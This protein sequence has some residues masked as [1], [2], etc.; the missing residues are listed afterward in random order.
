MAT[1]KKQLRD[2]DGNTI[3]PDVG[4]DLDS[5]VFSDDPTEPV[6]SLEPWIETEDITDGAIT[7]DKID[8]S[9]FPHII[10]C[11]TKNYSALNS[12]GYTSMSVTIPTQ[13][14]TNYYVS[15]A[16][17]NGNAYWTK[18]FFKI[19]GK[20]TT[21][22]TIYVYNDGTTGQNSGA[23]VVNYIVAR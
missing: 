11:G 10:A 1:Y 14:D 5:V 6:G 3:Y 15:V 8:F 4:L 19:G 7:D 20:T 2:K 9:T 16:N 23:G 22:F 12:Q 18:I 13:P 17:D 21:G